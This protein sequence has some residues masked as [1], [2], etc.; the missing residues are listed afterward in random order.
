MKYRFEIAVPSYLCRPDGRL[1]IDG[2]AALMGEAAWHHARSFG[3]AFTE[4]GVQQF[5]ILHRLGFRILRTPSWG[6]KITLETWPSR[7]QRLFAMREFVISDDAGRTMVEASSA[8]LILDAGTRRPVRPENLL[9]PE[10]R[11]DEVPLEMPTGKL[12]G[13]DPGTVATMLEGA[14]WHAVRPADIDL[15]N[16]VNNARYVQ[17]IEDHRPAYP[18]P[19]Q[20]CM[21]SYLSETVLGQEFTVITEKDGE[22]IEVWTRPDQTAA[23]T[24]PDDAAPVCACRF[25]ILTVQ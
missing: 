3:V 5:W 17:W 21:V 20:L 12:P 4:E 15:N 11:V 1:H 13:I 24:K 7:M 6:E 8:W 23:A 19:S 10:W 25:N 18:D 14:R 9:S 22:A 16:H 2:L